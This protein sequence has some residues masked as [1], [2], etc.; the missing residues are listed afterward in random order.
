MQSCK[1]WAEYAAMGGGHSK[2]QAKGLF[3]NSTQIWLPQG[4]A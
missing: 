4:V 3:I 1:C 2:S